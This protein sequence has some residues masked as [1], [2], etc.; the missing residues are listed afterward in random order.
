M[1]KVIIISVVVILILVSVGLYFYNQKTELAISE[2]PAYTLESNSFLKEYAENKDASDTKYLNKTIQVSGEIKAITE[3]SNGLNVELKAGQ[4]ME[5]V[6]CSID[7]SQLEKA[8]QLVVG[9]KATLKGRCGGY[10]YEEMLG[11]KNI[12]LVQCSIIK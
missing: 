6:T 9:S 8:Q 4:E 5:T 10:L 1:K 2:P 11:M 12:G 3:I 7:S